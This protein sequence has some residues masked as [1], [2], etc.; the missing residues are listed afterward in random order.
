MSIHIVNLAD[1]AILPISSRMNVRVCALIF[2]AGIHSLFGVEAA[3]ATELLVNSESTCSLWFS[4]RPKIVQQ[5]DDDQ[6]NY[7]NYLLEGPSAAVPAKF[8]RIDDRNIEASFHTDPSL[9]AN[10]I[11]DFLEIGGEAWIPNPDFKIRNS[12]GNTLSFR[13]WLIEHGRNLGISVEHV[14]NDGRIHI[15]KISDAKRRFP[16]VKRVSRGVFVESQYAPAPFI[17][18]FGIYE[19]EKVAEKSTPLYDAYFLGAGVTG[20][21]YRIIPKWNPNGSYVRKVFKGLE[22][23]LTQAFDRFGLEVMK[24]ASEFRPVP[25]VSV[26]QIHSAVGNQMILDDTRGVCLQQAY[27]E[28]LTPDEQDF[29]KKRLADFNIS[30]DQY[31][32]NRFPSRSALDGIVRH[33]LPHLK[34]ENPEWSDEKIVAA[35]K[36]EA[37]KRQKSWGLGADNW[38]GNVDIP[39]S[40]NPFSAFFFRPLHINISYQQI[41]IDPDTLHMTIIDPQ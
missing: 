28:M 25:G 37:L 6:K 15:K 8:S 14:A 21:V 11:L 23:V 29:I 26:V 40:W 12:T 16:L 35:A 34:K 24:G 4:S 30:L 5:S 41:I 31:M 13:G 39:M 17:H 18:R 22:G 20:S 36:E 3:H 19:G 2:S 9:R 38:A 33:V 1:F 7:L 27:Y 32:K 10:A